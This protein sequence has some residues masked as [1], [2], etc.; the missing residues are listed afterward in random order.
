M[1]PHEDFG[2]SE[3]S[4]TKVGISREDAEA[5]L[6]ESATRNSQ[7]DNAPCQWPEAPSPEAFHGLAGQFVDIVSP[8]TEADSMALLIQFL[9]FF[10]NAAGRSSYFQVEA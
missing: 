6:R 10:G 5:F 2:W 7:A 3:H 9:V 8:H 1:S 4:I